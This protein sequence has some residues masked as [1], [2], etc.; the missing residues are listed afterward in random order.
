MDDPA[1]W[2][3]PKADGTLDFSEAYATGMGAWDVFTVKWLYTEF[4]GGGDDRAAL[5]RM[6]SEAYG[7]GLRFVSDAHARTVDTGHPFGS[8]WDN[9]ADP[10]AALDETMQVRAIA[11]KN[12]GPGALAPGRP[13]SDLN[14]VIVPI[15][16]YHRYQVDAAAKFIG[17]LDFRYAV[18][19]AGAEEAKPV[20]ASE[21]RRA[22]AA[23]IRTLDPA[24]LDLPDS[25]LNQ[26]TPGDVGYAGGGAQEEVFEGKT[27]PV[28]DLS[29]AADTAARLTL[30]AVLEPSRANRLAAYAQRRPDVMTLG[31]TLDA[32]DAAVFA[33]QAETRRAALNQV[34]QARFVSE[35]IGLSRQGD[36]APGV[37]AAVDAKLAAIKARLDKKSR[38]RT[39]EEQA[40]VS[41]LA[42][43]IGRHLSGEEV[44]LPP[45]PEAPPGSP[46]G[47]MGQVEECWHCV[48]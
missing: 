4:P 34:V 1:P 10:V 29:A 26:L 17:G 2:V 20:A 46:I 5:D 15:Y 33:A 35:L 12:F 24:A 13:T 32:L 40:H 8:V 27:G 48:P 44:A 6:V 7:A 38:T 41:R 19:G 47:A 39:A 3:H 21:Q 18:T 30:G 36:A 23:L 42:A 45:A 28:F 14:A 11:L 37:R 43:G 9:G 16:L 25:L 22:L 31:E